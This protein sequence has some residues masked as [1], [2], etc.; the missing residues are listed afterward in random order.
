MMANLIEEKLEE[1]L[2][3][4]SKPAR[5]TGGE[6]NS[7]TKD[8][9]SV[10][11]K[12][13][14]GFP[15]SYEIGM[16]N[17]ALSIV[18]NL[19]NSRDD[20]VAERVYNPW[21][22]MEQALRNHGVPLYTL[23]TRTPVRD[24]D[25]LALAL[26]Y[27]L[28]YSNVLGML[29]LAG[30]PLRSVDRDCPQSDESARSDAENRSYPLVLAGGHATFSPEPV[31]PFID[32][33]IIGE[34]EAVL[35]DVTECY[36]EYRNLPREELL[37]KLAN[38]EGVYVPRFYEQRYHE[39]SDPLYE[40]QDERFKDA[41]RRLLKEVVP[42][43]D[44]V[45]KRINRK[46]VW[47]VDNVPYPT[48]PV[49]PFIEVVHD[50]ISLEVMRGCTR[51]CR[52]C[53]AGMITRPVREKSPERLRELAAELVAN[54][55]HEDISLVSL[56]TADYTRV[57]EVVA[58]MIETYG[59]R[60]IGVSLPSLRADVSTVNMVKEIQKVRKTGLTFA[61]EAGSQRMRDVTNKGVREED[62][63][64]AA[65]TAFDAGWQRIKFYFMISL[66]T[67]TDEDVIGIADLATRVAKLARRM[68]VRNPTIAIGVSTFVPK[69]NTPWQWH[70]QDSVEEV[71]RK[72]S[73]IRR[74]IG[75]KGV[76]FRYHN[77][78][79][80]H[81]EA[82]LSL[83]DRRLADAIELAW[84]KGAKFDSWDEYF[85]YDL[86]MEAFA[87]SGI[88]PY[89]IANRQKAYEEA[90]PWDHID[91]G[92]TKAYNKKEDRL[93]REGTFT[94]DCHTAPCTMCQACDRFVLEGIGLK[95]AARGKT[96]LPLTMG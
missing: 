96:L 22:D 15:D 16:S 50:R 47:D 88:D 91:C 51:G 78:E 30:I 45:P 3:T 10:E 56:S 42:T 4:I 41:D 1:I 76:L 34:A 77:P 57:E 33:F 5:Y 68:K 73:L 72:Q 9:G 36:K 11:V 69:P 65:E 43:R 12:W 31:A 71:R 54:T 19:L 53:Q 74:H 48:A 64:A 28:C 55:G 37:V 25:F 59:D 29:D 80:S 52:F 49:I 87:E 8:H 75:D 93:S 84:R 46:I 92:V 81:L 61:P 13:A 35:P 14:V 95:A 2:P 62:I 70:V 24:Y 94:A 18:Y 79:S 6:L 60:K 66:P 27:E 40:C 38:V 67:E 86:W 21:P 63:F 82:V 20:C 85:K 23:E 39:Y 58:D 7:I 26:S 32:L 83:G 44:N 17:L 90:L 89:F